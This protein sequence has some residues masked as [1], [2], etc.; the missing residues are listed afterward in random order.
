MVNLTNINQLSQ[1]RA[2]ADSAGMPPDEPLRLIIEGL[3]TQQDR[4]ETAIEALGP[5][6]GKQAADAARR[7]IAGSMRR[8]MWQASMLRQAILAGAGIALFAAGYFVA[9]QMPVETS[10][11]NMP[12]GLADVM[13][14]QQWQR[15][16]AA[17]REQKKETHFEWCLL[18]LI[19]KVAPPS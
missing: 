3:A 7:E 16:W 4:L 11:G 12:A 15:S 9:R 19:T 13:H 18:P 5:D 6:A 1:A 8:L 17:C 2:H 10:I 14:L